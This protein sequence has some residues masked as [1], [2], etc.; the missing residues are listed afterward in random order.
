MTTMTHTHIGEGCEI[1][2]G[3]GGALTAQGF[4]VWSAESKAASVAFCLQI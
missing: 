2:S 3:S 1:G 4:C